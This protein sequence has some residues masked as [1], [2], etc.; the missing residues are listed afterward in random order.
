MLISIPPKSAI[1]GIKREKLLDCTE[2]ERKLRNFLR[3]EIP[4][5]G[6]FVFD[7]RAGRRDDPHLLVQNGPSSW[8]IAK[9]TTS[10][11]P[12]LVDPSPPLA[13]LQTPSF[14]EVI[15]VWADK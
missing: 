1:S 6:A 14:A 4:G 8:I 15:N 10:R 12:S 5:E 11:T 3:P 9:A 13:F 2:C 7:R